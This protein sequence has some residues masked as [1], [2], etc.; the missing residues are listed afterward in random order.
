MSQSEL[1]VQSHNSTDHPDKRTVSIRSHHNAIK[2]HGVSFKIVMTNASRYSA[3]LMGLSDHV[4]EQFSCIGA[5]E[6][7]KPSL[8]GNRAKETP[9]AISK[10]MK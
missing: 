3:Y 8:K 1:P 10:G 7:T 9:T 6:E 5:D 4:H 2:R